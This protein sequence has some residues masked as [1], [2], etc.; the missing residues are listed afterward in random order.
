MGACRLSDR[1]GHVVPSLSRV[2]RANLSGT[3]GQN[4][5]SRR[6]PPVTFPPGRSDARDVGGAGRDLTTGSIPRHLMAFSLAMRAGRD[7]PPAP[8][9]CPAYCSSFRILSS[10]AQH[11]RV[12]L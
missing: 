7:L 1:S 11:S 5:P 3:T 9:S 12:C 8:S 10:R 6:D 2:A 4:G